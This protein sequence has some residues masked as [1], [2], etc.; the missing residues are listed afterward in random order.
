MSRVLAQRLRQF[1]NL[2]QRFAGVQTA[3]GSVVKL[4][5]AVTCTEVQVRNAVGSSCRKPSC[6]PA[7]ILKS[8]THRSARGTA[9]LMC[10]EESQ[11]EWPS[12]RRGNWIV[13]RPGVAEKTVVRI[14]NL[15]V[16]ETLSG[17]SQGIGD[18]ADLI[19]RDVLVASAPEEEHG[20]LQFADAPEQA[21]VI[22]VRCDAS[23]V[24]GN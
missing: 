3:R 6:G 12:L 4:Q 21:G 8:G 20:S 1:F 18:R 5:I 19:C 23:S 22:R 13:S 17:C 15:Y 7:R 2:T 24:I 10:F 14:G 16:Y 11:C 9:G